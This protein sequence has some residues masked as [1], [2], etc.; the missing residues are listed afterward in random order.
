M[1]I[2]IDYLVLSIKKQTYEELFSQLHMDIQDFIEIRSYYGT[3]NCVYH[4]GIKV[5][6]NLKVDDKGL[7]KRQEYID[8]VILDLS[9]KG[10]RAVEQINNCNFDWLGFLKKYD[11]MFRSGDAH[12]ARM[13]IACDDLDGLL[14]MKKLQSYTY[15]DKFVCRSKKVPQLVIKGQETI[16]FGSEKSDRRLRIYNKALEQGK[17]THWIRCE[18]QLRND[19]AMAFYLNWLNY[20]GRIGEL[21]AGVLLDYLRFVELPKGMDMQMIKQHSNQHRLPTAW[22]WNRFLQTC[23]RIPQLY[24]PG[25]EYDFKRLERAVKQ[26]LSSVKTLLLVNGGD[27]S[28]YINDVNRAKLNR[29]QRDLIHSLGGDPDD[30]VGFGDEE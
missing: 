14:D 5:H 25:E 22:W 13:D 28:A 11:A 9:G 29:V 8:L 3:T 30:Q 26:G 20:E 24:L 23:N 19:N 10:C 2:V 16:Y 7:G 17:D 21:F 4:E 18:F 27:V 12:I 1:N 15:N 6:W